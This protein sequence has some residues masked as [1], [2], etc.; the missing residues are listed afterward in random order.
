VNEAELENLGVRRFLVKPY[1]AVALL[2]T[3]AANAR[4][5]AGQSE[6]VTTETITWTS[7]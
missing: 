7:C 3:V 5:R 2:Q 6:I 4:S 1:N